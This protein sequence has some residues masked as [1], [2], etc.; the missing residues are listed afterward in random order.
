MRLGLQRKGNKALG[1]EP[2]FSLRAG[3]D[4]RRM[5][6]MCREILGNPPDNFNW[7]GD[8][9]SPNCLNEI[10]APTFLRIQRPPPIGENFAMLSLTEILVHT[11]SVR[12]DRRVVESS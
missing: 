8:D 5:L 2:G 7:G 6:P 9:Y 3:E 12:E 10:N 11:N 4:V 1:T